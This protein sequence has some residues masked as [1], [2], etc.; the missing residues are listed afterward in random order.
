MQSFYFYP[1][2]LVN[3]IDLQYFRDV[4]KKS[5]NSENYR[6]YGHDCNYMVLVSNLV[7]Y[8]CYNLTCRLPLQVVQSLYPFIQF[9]QSSVPSKQPTP[10]HS[11]HL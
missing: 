1:N 11:K 2:I 7:L 6:H 9:E 3:D 4:M 5:N 10:S 8:M